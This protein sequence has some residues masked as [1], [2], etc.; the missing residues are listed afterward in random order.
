MSWDSVPPGVLY[1]NSDIAVS[2]QR[3]QDS[4]LVPRSPATR[5]FTPTDKKR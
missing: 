2:P 3:E 4:H 1:L 5:A